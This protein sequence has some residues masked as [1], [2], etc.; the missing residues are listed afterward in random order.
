MDKKV[1]ICLENGDVFEGY[2]FGAD[3]EVLGELVFTTGMG[4][5]IETLT[6]PSYYGQ[7]VMQTFPLIGNYGIIGAD[8]ESKKSYVSAYI[9]REKCD[10]PSNF[11]CEETLD[12]F[13]KENGIVGVYGVDTREITKIIREAGVMNAF[14]T[15]DV[16]N[17]DSE[18]LTAYRVTDAVKSVSEKRAAL[19]PSDSHKYNVVLLDFGAKRNIVRELQKRGC[20]VAVMPYD[21]KAED[22]L[23]LGVDGIMLSNGPG[24]PAE[25]TE[26]IEEIKKLVGKVPIFGICLGHQLLALA[27][28]GETTKLKYGHR[29]VNQPVKNLKTGRTYISSQNHGYAVINESVESVGG[30]VSY[31]NA[32]DGTC[33]GVDY[34]DKKAFS[35]QFH[36]EACS[37]PHDT[38]FIFDKFID[39]MGGSENASE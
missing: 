37:G 25:N 6:D 4:G 10:N 14:I 13:L 31:I 35:V 29:G 27:M 26:I 30:V 33:E 24:D 16:R 2:R 9:V 18:K 36:P 5:Y 11:R 20:N 7:I 38:R 21:T 12:A 8:M 28:G 32:N 3:G 19:H 39:M 22:I 17:I 15:S 34:P 23:K 1:Y